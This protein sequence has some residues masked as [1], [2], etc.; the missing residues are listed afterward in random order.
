MR[1][2]NELLHIYRKVMHLCIYT[3][4]LHNSCIGLVTWWEIYQ[5]VGSNPLHS[6]VNLVKPHGLFC[7]FFR[8]LPSLIFIAATS[9]GEMVKHEHQFYALYCLHSALQTWVASYQMSTSI[10]S[11]CHYKPCETC[12]LQSPLRYKATLCKQEALPLPCERTDNS[13]I[14]FFIQPNYQY[15]PPYIK[16]AYIRWTDIRLHSVD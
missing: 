9:P 4:H 13:S 2:N 8:N 11:L 16:I 12:S 15:C 3:S 14:S 10:S 5:A 7:A 6:V 1:T